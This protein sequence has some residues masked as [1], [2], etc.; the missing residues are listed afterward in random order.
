LGIRLKA[1][2][3]KQHRLAD[4]ADAGRWV[5]RPAWI[6]VTGLI[7]ATAVMTGWIVRVPELVQTRTGAVMAFNAAFCFLLIAAALVLNDP[8][9]RR[10]VVAQQ[11]IGASILL[12]AGLAGSQHWFN[13]S[14]GLD[15]PELHRWIGADTPHPG[16]M[17]KPAIA[18][19]LMSGA[20]LILMHR[21]RGLWTGLLVQALTLTIAGMGAVGLT[22]IYL[23]LEQVYPNYLFGRF[24][25]HTA[26]AFLL[27]GTGFWLC[28]RDAGWY[29]SRHLI[30]RE[31]QQ[32]AWVG[33][34]VLGLVVFV[35]T[36]T[37][38]RIT[39]NAV[40]ETLADGL[41]HTLRS[42][43]NSFTINIDQRIERAR[44]LATRPG[45]I[46]RLRNLRTQP[47]DKALVDGL[48]R[49]AESFRPLGISGVAYYSPDRREWLRVGH[50][51]D[52]PELEVALAR[53]PGSSLLWHRGLVLRTR[54]PMVG[55]G[56]VVGWVV[57]EQ[58]VP[59]LTRTYAGPKE[60]GETREV[61]VCAVQDE[62]FRCFP[63]RLMPR[64][65]SVP[66]ARGLPMAR[67][68][69]GATGVMETRDYRNQKVLAAYGPIG[70]LG[71]GMVVKM[72]TVELYAP[73]RARFET[74]LLMLCA[75]GVAGAALL[76]WKIKPLAGELER[77][78]E[79]IRQQAERALDES[80][81]RRAAVIDSAMDAIISLDEAQ[82]VV[83]FNAAAEKMFGYASSDMIGQTLDRLLP[84]RSRS[85]HRHHV[86]AFGKTGVTNRTMGHLG[87]ISGMRAS[88]EEFPIEASISQT[89]AGPTKRY[90]V[91]LRDITERQ[92]AEATLRESERR[93]SDMLS[94]V[95][96]ISMTLDRNARVTF[97][98]DYLLRLTGWER[99]EVLG[100]DWFERF[101][102]P[103]AG[104]VKAVF[105]ALLD[106][107]PAAWHHE[108][109]ILTRS[110]ERRL[111]RWNNSALRSPSEEEVI[112]TASIGEDITEHRRA[113][114][115]LQRSF[116]RL[117][118]LSRRLVEVEDEERRNINRELHDRVGQ[119][120]A[121]VKLN[122]ELIR[123]MLA[124][125]TRRVVGT[126]LDDAQRLVQS[127]IDHARN[128]M[129]DLRPPGLDDFGLRVALQMH[130]ETVAKRLAI[131]VRL[132]GEELKPRLPPAIETA[133]YRIVQEALNN[134]VKHAGA[135]NI[136]IAFDTHDGVLTLSIID[137]GIG[138]NMGTTRPD[139]Y[140]LRIM[141]ERAEAVGAHFEVY[142]APGHGSRI[143]VSLERPV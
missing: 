29:R 35:A 108:N 52:E 97:C 66:Y 69:A 31:D 44:I 139:S 116:S 3:R 46:E 114:E 63:Q 133:L 78:R 136:E 76:Y 130:A 137:D 12:I 72:D 37:G 55:D 89:G 115:E 24:A 16:R 109:E 99:E 56:E 126:R 30:A 28:W 71:L 141:R 83:L 54:V 107:A 91:I 27:A 102:P 113:E 67:A 4:L 23:E 38:F 119:D 120:L 15:W 60:F 41:R 98:N 110:G 122:I 106:D 94:K 80:E 79:L 75:I 118:E 87:A 93:Y 53:P 17:L 112:G 50:F 33:A 39:Q 132:V 92:K 7:G 65:S 36:V 61:G 96:L 48:R 34:A 9:S 10:R 85:V 127:A 25:P 62:W 40:R 121:A 21:V 2:V 64:V 82:H 111:I 103:E 42:D 32:I 134:V 88:G 100:S 11:S 1:P 95:E 13:Y 143:T 45:S 6:G 22:G 104:D 117:Q 138:F 49:V 20:V 70:G 51:A 84:E 135:S 101:I 73:I 125:D 26:T 140:G 81:R 18:G 68:L 131:P 5:M 105:A 90:T 57:L 129:A 8:A 19:F 77:S 124:E 86:E 128:I 58:S 47:D 74:A 59:A 142:S 43:V 123:T 14:L